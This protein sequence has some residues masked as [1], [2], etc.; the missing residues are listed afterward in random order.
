ML[1]IV[2]ALFVLV[3]FLILS[4][5]M[6]AQGHIRRHA[7]KESTEHPY[8][9]MVQDK[10]D[11]NRFGIAQQLKR[12]LRGGAVFSHSFHVMGGIGAV[13]LLALP[14][15]STGG[16]IVIGVALPILALFALLV[17][18]SLAELASAIPTS[19]GLYHWASAL[20]GRKWGFHAGLLHLAGYLAMLAF[21]N[22]AAG[23]LL[24]G[25]LSQR[26]GLAGS[27]G[28]QTAAVLAV[29]FAQAAVNHWGRAAAM[30]A[31]GVWL[32]A[33][34][35]AVLI[36]GLVWLAWPAFYSP[37]V[38]AQPLAQESHSGA[39]ARLWAAAGGAL[40]L[41]KLFTG[42]EAASHAAEEAVNPRV[43]VPWAVYLAPAYTFIMAYCM[44]AAMALTLPWFAAGAG[45]TALDPIGAGGIIHFAPV[46][47]AIAAAAL[48]LSGFQTMTACSRLLFSMSRDEALPFS[49]TWAAVGKRSYTPYAA[50]WLSAVLAFT[51]AALSRLGMGSGSLVFWLA[52]SLLGA[53]LSAAIVLA[54]KLAE[55]NNH[56]LLR[57]GI[58]KLGRWGRGADWLAFG[59]LVAITSIAAVALSLAAAACMAVCWAL[60]WLMD[61]RVR[62]RHLSAMQSRVKTIRKETVR[63]E[64]KFRF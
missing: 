20:G 22:T 8:V 33:L 44:L 53:H 43:Q 60:I 5:A 6:A 19:G 58:W 50:V 21:T 16:L 37:F 13:L 55:G 57:D 25:L 39:G 28:F 32:Q 2:L 15:V 46:M 26:F 4:G 59:W 38:L 35:A 48:G 30:S 12:G 1:G 40:L 27:P 42:G 54:V 34:A 3:C 18:A 11:L 23:L 24:A 63:I 31:A 17:N 52:V 51:A 61:R 36:A 41:Q 9:R 47:G 64:R 45:G 29:T 14:A 10:Y 7:G 49:R 56:P 62:H